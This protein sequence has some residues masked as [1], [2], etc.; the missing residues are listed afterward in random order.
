MRHC[1]AS[2]LRRLGGAPLRVGGTAIPSYYDPRYRCEM[3]ILRF[4]SRRPGARYTA[5]VEAVCER[6]AEVLVIARPA[7]AF[8]GEEARERFAP[9]WMPPAELAYGV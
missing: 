9:D 2:I 8:E 6:M 7:A 4:D 5:L 1:S 3:E